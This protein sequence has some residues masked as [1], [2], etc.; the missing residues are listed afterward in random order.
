MDY[1]K[2]LKKVQAILGGEVTKNH[3]FGVFCFKNPGGRQFAGHCP[4]PPTP[5]NPSG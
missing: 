4:G 2:K 1:S 5:A 3:Q